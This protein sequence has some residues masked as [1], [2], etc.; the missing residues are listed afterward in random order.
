MKFRDQVLASGASVGHVPSGYKRVG[1]KVI[2]RS[3]Q[4]LTSELGN[5]ILT[6]FPWCTGVFHHKTTIG[7]ARKPVLLFLAGEPITEVRHR[8]NGVTYIFDIG[9]TTFS[10][11][12]SQLRKRMVNEIND[13]ENLLDMFAAVGNL[14]LQPLV[15]RDIDAV[16]V[17]RDEITYSYLLK[18]LEKNQ[19][20]RDIAK[21]LDCRDLTLSNW[22]DRILMGYHNVDPTHL[23]V[24]CDAAKTD[25]IIHLHPLAKID[26]YSEMIKQY[27]NWIEQCSVS[28]T[29]I[30]VHKIKNYSPGLQHIEVVFSIT[31]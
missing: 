7:E 3:Q 21:N 14:S 4:N 18:T 2:L 11:G 25:A 31:K 15:K 22:A 6:L 28:I 17:E 27:Q 20:G 24:A 30:E 29:S 26:N 8:E 23:R 5:R 10:G 13:G 1:D 12:N 16:L 19:I 9:L